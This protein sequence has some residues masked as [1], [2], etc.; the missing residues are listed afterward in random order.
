MLRALTRQWPRAVW[1]LMMEMPK[2]GTRRRGTTTTNFL[3][4]QNARKSSHKLEMTTTCLLKLLECAYL[5]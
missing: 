1:C 2:L 3:A 4:I 5:T